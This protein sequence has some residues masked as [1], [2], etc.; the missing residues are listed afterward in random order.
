VRLLYFTGQNEEGK[1]GS[2][3]VTTR[4][5]YKEYLVIREIITDGKAEK[6]LFSEFYI[7]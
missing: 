1:P 7:V 4:E 5:Y 2:L 6:A 3:S